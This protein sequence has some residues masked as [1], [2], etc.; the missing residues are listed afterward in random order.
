MISIINQPKFTSSS[1]TPIIIPIEELLN[2]IFITT[3]QHFPIKDYVVAEFLK[4]CGLQ[5]KSSSLRTC[6]AFLRLMK[7]F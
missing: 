7:F 1:N 4:T 3:T 5:F 6:I 2:I